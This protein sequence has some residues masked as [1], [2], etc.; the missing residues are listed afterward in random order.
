MGAAPPGSLRRALFKEKPKAIRI[1]TFGFSLS[2]FK[3]D[4]EGLSLPSHLKYLEVISCLGVRVPDPRVPNPA[5][6]AENVFFYACFGTNSFNYRP[7]ERDTGE[8][9]T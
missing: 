9:F 1:L 5:L 6:L 7:K 4:K 8:D 2:C 3:P